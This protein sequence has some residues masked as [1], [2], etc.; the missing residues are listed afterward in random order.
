MFALTFKTVNKWGRKSFL[1]VLDQGLFSSGN[2]LINILLARWLNPEEYG[3][4]AIAFS[5]MLF[6]AG[7]AN[8]LIF[9]PM[10][11]FGSTYFKETLSSYLSKVLRGYIGLSITLSILFV[12]LSL[13]IKGDI[14]KILLSCAIALPFILI[15]WFY[16]RTFYLTSKLSSAAILSGINSFILIFGIITFRYF[17]ILSATS[18]YLIF[19]FASLLSTL[20][21]SITFQKNNNN[22]INSCDFK[23]VLNKHWEFGKWIML[24]SFASSITTLIYAPMLGL[25]ASI[26]EAGAFKAIQNLITPFQQILAALSLL[27]LPELSYKAHTLSKNNFFN[28][29]KLILTFFFIFGLVYCFVILFFGEEIITTLYSN[30]FYSN[31]Y[32]LLYPFSIIIIISG[33][34]EP[35]SITFRAFEN[36]KI[37]LLSKF[38]SALFILISCITFITKMKILGVT[39]CMMISINFELLIQIYF[40]IKIFKNNKIYKREK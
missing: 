19:I 21:F 7:V 6:F 18:A 32:W 37:I 35:L 25:F 15:V 40:L 27:I 12:I 17:D 1:A 16:R 29:L 3:G 2:F 34:L 22:M 26:N 23:I 30:N 36:P 24:A 20:V 10:M 9:E 28:T 14:K 33:V 13:F 11:I 8:S 38:I 4:F 39:I 31:F 5:I